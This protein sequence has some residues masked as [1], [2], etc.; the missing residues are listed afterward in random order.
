[1]FSVSAQLGSVRSIEIFKY[2]KYFVLALSF[3]K[4]CEILVFNK[5]FLLK[6]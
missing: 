2:L 5:S 6:Y 3:M 1:M 4:V